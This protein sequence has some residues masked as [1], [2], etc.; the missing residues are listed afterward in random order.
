MQRV[1]RRERRGDAVA[2]I[3]SGDLVAA[4][5]EAPLSRFHLRAVVAS[6][7][8]FFTDAY[9]LFIIGVASA[10]I[11]GDWH[12]AVQTSFR[13]QRHPA[14][15]PGRSPGLRP[16]RGHPRPDP[17][18]RAGGRDHGPRGAGHRAGAE[19]VLAAVACRFVL[20]IGIGGDYPVSAVMA[21]EYANR[22]DRGKLVSLVFASQALGL[23]IGP[24]V[25]L[26]LLASGV[27][28]ELA[29][30][31]MLGL[32]ALPPPR[33]LY[34]R[35]K[36]PESPRYAA[37][38]QGARP[39]RPRAGYRAWWRAVGAGPAATGRTTLRAF[40]TNRTVAAHP[41]A[42]RAPGSCSTTSTTGTPS[43]PRSSS[44]G[45]ARGQPAPVD[46]VELI[47]FAL[48]AVPGL[49]LRV[50]PWTGSAIAGSSGRF[51]GDGALLRADR[52]HPGAD[53]RHRPLPPHLRDQLLLHRV[54]AQHDHLPDPHRGVRGRACGPP[55]T[56]SPPGWASWAP[57][58]ASSSSRCSALRWA[59]AER[60]C[61]PPGWPAAALTRVLPEPAGHSL[62]D[63]AVST[64]GPAARSLR[65]AGAA[66]RSPDLS[67]LTA[68]TD[69]VSPQGTA[70][71]DRLTDLPPLVERAVAVAQLA[72]D[73]AGLVATRR[74]G[75]PAAASSAA[76]A[77][78]PRRAGRNVIWSNVAAHP[79]PSGTGPGSRP[80]PFPA[81]SR[82]SAK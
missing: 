49:R 18:V 57:S 21:S 17:G 43:P 2:D 67:S 70:A 39:S 9:D 28:H 78:V 25:A 5:D 59:W 48:F 26:A 54:R 10:L 14:G 63:I 8:G 65:I 45:G 62:E 19:L 6:G 33:V 31:L 72:P 30:R 58:S 42:R 37:Q 60:C 51:P 41:P 13:G 82:E 55:G 34:L 61:S 74:F 77:Q 75:R 32:G 76:V 46:R 56:A 80:G 71:Y 11:K 24:V 50:P 3:Q 53:H 12:L 29:W 22:K 36:T 68:A 52:V 66:V 79:C 23:I 40:L 38:V 27:N 1:R 4:L 73:L 47:I 69:L 81:G 20:G 7:M 44:A 16:G 64:P 35:I 15:H